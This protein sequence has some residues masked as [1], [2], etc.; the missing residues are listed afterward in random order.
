MYPSP[1]IQTDPDLFDEAIHLFIESMVSNNTN[2][3]EFDAMKTLVLQLRKKTNVVKMFCSIF[4]LIDKYSD[5]SLYVLKLVLIFVNLVKINRPFLLRLGRRFLPELSTVLLLTF[6]P[7]N[8]L[9]QKE[10]HY[11]TQAIYLYLAHK[12]PLPDK[13]KMGRPLCEKAKITQ[14]ETP[15]GLRDG[16]NAGARVEGLR[17]G[18]DGYN[19][20]PAPKLE[21]LQSSG[22]R[23]R[24]S[25]LKLA[26]LSIKDTDDIDDESIFA[27]QYSCLPP[28][29]VTNCSL[30]TKAPCTKTRKDQ[31][32]SSSVKFSPIKS[33]FM[34]L[35]GR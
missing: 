25:S 28:T 22:R 24:S 11:A 1:N 33:G 29:D 10:C 9:Y 35:F 31:P 13:D 4:V 32:N 21:P 17:N 27:Q 3:I 5:N 19:E 7:P 18:S 26:A 12:R 34:K 2:D 8:D 23:R 15:M 20:A 30:S 6:E 14:Q 16:A